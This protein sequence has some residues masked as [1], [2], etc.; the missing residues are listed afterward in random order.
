[1]VDEIATLDAETARQEV[2][3]YIEE[4]GDFGATD[5]EIEAALAFRNLT[6]RVRQHR[7]DLVRMGDIFDS[8]Q[9]RVSAGS[10]KVAK[11]WRCGTAEERKKA[12]K[13]RKYWPLKPKQRIQKVIGDMEAYKEQYLREKD[14]R[15]EV[16][17]CVYVDAADLGRWISILKTGIDPV[18]SA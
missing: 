1:M 9:R 16:N 5:I 12:A 10:R 13:S 11:V 3:A 2:L 17:S 7:L 15:S 18:K 14:S 6:G 8:G 4:Q